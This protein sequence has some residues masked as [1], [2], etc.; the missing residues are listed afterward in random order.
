MRRPKI[1]FDPQVDHRARPREP[2]A[3]ARRERLGLC[4]LSQAKHI[5]IEGPGLR[6]ATGG[7]RKLNVIKGNE[8]HSNRVRIEESLT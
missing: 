8:S 7:H 1:A 5:S 2:A 4:D 6:F 3:T